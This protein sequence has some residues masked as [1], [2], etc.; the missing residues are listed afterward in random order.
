MI[1][2]IQRAREEA[3]EA[4][5]DSRVDG[6]LV[7]IPGLGRYQGSFSDHFRVIQTYSDQE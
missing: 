2:I 3:L 4:V 7:F 1:R 6:G 5:G